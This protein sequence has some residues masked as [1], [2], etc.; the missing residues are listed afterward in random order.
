MSS[1]L[2]STI[3]VT[4]DPNYQVTTREQALDLEK[5][6]ETA[7]GDNAEPPKEEPK[8]PPEPEPKETPLVETP[9]P[10]EPA[11]PPPAAP[12][13]SPETPPA[14]PLAHPD[15]EPDEELDQIRIGADARPETIEV[16]R[17]L[18]G[19]V[20]TDKKQIKE[21]QRRLETQDGELSTLRTSVRPVADPTVQ[22]ELTELRTFKQQH[23]I[24]DDT[25][26]HAEFE[27]PVR[28][29][30][31]EIIKD[32]V[33][34]SVDKDQAAEWEKQMRSAGPDRLDRTYWNE[35]V[36]NQCGDPLHRE[37][38]IR[39][40][41]SLMDAQEK[42]NE[43]RTKVAAQPDGYQ[44]YRDQQAKNYW[45]QFTTEATDEAIKLAP[46]LGEWA[47]PKDVTLAK[48]ATE[49]AAFEA[50]NKEY[51]EWEDLFQ[52][53]LTEVATQGPRGMTRVALSA[54]AGERFRRERDA[55]NAK[56]T[57]LQAEL[58]TAQDELNKI[59]GARSRVSTVSSGTSTR[60]ETPR[61]KLGQSVADAFKEHF[62][63]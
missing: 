1:S 33:N 22:A 11:E 12:K 7:F 48:S 51:K 45:G 31:D 2:G 44:Q 14:E 54:V 49:R 16:V 23:Q 24:F 9:E 40:V 61:T 38:L 6:F 25:G 13:L 57:K 35:G 53:V 19:M 8:A 52:K 41:L 32:V 30:F 34:L 27:Q 5:A 28:Q 55:A 59:A 4:R 43:F 17:T 37:R 62:G 26:Y 56:I 58:K 60:T 21:L 50:H 10:K 46:T 63:S 39:K 3:P 29:I 15:D 42:R 20:K 18:R 47:S 36:I